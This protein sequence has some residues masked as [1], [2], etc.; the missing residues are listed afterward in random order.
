[1]YDSDERS[2]SICEEIVDKLSFEKD[3]SSP[4]QLTIIV[5]PSTPKRK[6]KKRK[7][8]DYNIKIL[9]S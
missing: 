4:I 5:P 3:A 7:S 8:K 6:K 9:T 2:G 1:L